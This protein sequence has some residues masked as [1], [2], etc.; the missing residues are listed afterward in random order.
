MVKSAVA[1]VLRHLVLFALAAA[2]PGVWAGAAFAQS[3]TSVVAGVVA[4]ESGGVVAGVQLTLAEATGAERRAVSDAAGAYQFPALPPGRYALTAQRPGFGLARVDGI[5]LGDGERRSISLTMR[6]AQVSDAVTVRGAGPALVGGSA[7]KTDTPLIETPRSVSVIT[8]AQI[9]AQQVA[10]IDEVLRYTGGVGTEFRGID[11][12]RTDISMRGFNWSGFV[13]T[14]GMRGG[15]GVYGEFDVDPFGLERV[16]VLRGPAS[17]LYGAS[18]PGGLVN[19]V[20]KRPTDVFQGQLEV[21]TGSYDQVAGKFDVG[22]PLNR[23]KTLLFRL[24]GVAR[25]GGSQVDGVDESRV[26]LAPAFTWRPRP[27]TSVTFLASYQK[28]DAPWAIFLPAEGTVLPNPHGRIPTSRHLGES[29]FVDRFHRDFFTPAYFVEHQAGMWALRHSL[30][31][32]RYDFNALSVSGG[33][34]HEDGRTVSRYPWIGLEDGHAW[35]SD[36][37]VQRSVRLG[38][39]SHRFLAGLDFKTSAA[40]GGYGYTEGPPID[41]FAPVYGQTLPRDVPLYQDD[42]QETSQTGVYAQDQMRAGRLVLTA[43]GRYDRAT[44]DIRDRL[45]DTRTTQKDGAFTGQAGAVYLFDSGVAPFANVAQ[46]FEP[47]SGLDA[48]GE[49]FVPTTGTQVEAGLKYQ[50][51]GGASLV[52]VSGFVITQ[53][54]VLTNDPE[55]ARFSVQTGEVRS[56]GF[57]VDARLQLRS[58]F[59]VTASYTLSAAEITKSNGPDLGN[60]PAQTPRHLF[61]T[62]VDHAVQGRA[63]TGLRVRGGV[64]WRGDTLDY[65]NVIE[66]PAVTLVD[67]GLSYEFGGRLR[68]TALSLNVSNLLDETYVA[69]CEGA[70]WC[71]YGPRRVVTASLRH[72]W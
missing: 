61:S 49:A 44:S 26:F 5:V 28:D 25:T 54:N 24:T 35:T 3:G 18:S 23:S 11:K 22:G 45:S 50:P 30:R 13:F 41:I 62:W 53:Q 71:M 36:S 21:D 27:S 12:A 1:R 69:S 67:A 7:S 33:D 8:A 51:A 64:R 9:E 38:S 17:I 72:R 43:G 37:N 19:A 39:T 58:A 66:V 29:D 32:G 6:V 16:E 15:V 60:R 14:D 63:L 48:H 55:D 46:S 40:D 56:R 65:E 10:N 4:D 2:V 68:G 57:D 47:Q 34:L 70:Y 42:R 31:Y 59:D 20:S 52:T